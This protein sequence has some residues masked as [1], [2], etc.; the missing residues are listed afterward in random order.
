VSNGRRFIRSGNVIDGGGVFNETPE[1]LRQG[2]GLREHLHRHDG[3]LSQ[4][5]FA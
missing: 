4:I 1:A 3:H 5:G 2:E